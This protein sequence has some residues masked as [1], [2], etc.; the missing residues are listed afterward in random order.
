MRLDILGGSSGHSSTAT[1]NSRSAHHQFVRRFDA[2][3][4]V[5]KEMEEWQRLNGYK[6]PWLSWPASCRAAA[7]A[8]C[9]FAGSKGYLKSPVT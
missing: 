5:V 1:I 3:A 2:W 7:A 4:V 8:P 6:C 9:A